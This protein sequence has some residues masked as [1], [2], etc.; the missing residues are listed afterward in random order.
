LLEHERKEVV[1]HWYD[2]L[3]AMHNQ[4]K[5][6]QFIIKARIFGSCPSL[7]LKNFIKHDTKLRNISLITARL[8][9]FY[10]FK[11]TTF[12]PKL[13]ALL[14][15]PISVVKLLSRSCCDDYQRPFLW[16]AYFRS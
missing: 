14:L 2:K 13:N 7:M 12:L 15:G 3:E 6:S 16:F 11:M 9:I 10:F 1:K 4:S 8:G 5:G